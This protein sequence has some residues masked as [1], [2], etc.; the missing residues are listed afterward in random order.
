MYPI[1][2][3]DDLHDTGVVKVV[4]NLLG[5][6]LYFS[7]SLIP[8]PRQQVAHKVY[9]HVGL[10]AYRKTSL[11]RLARLP[12]TT[13]ETVES[14]EQLRWLEHG[15]R[16]RIVESVIPDRDHHGFSVDTP[17]DLARAEQMYFEKGGK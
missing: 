13:L 12:M 9:E 17:A 1:E 8:Y 5:D 2:R 16:I 15:L 7:R 6:A 4:T 10:Y 14:L 3:E 11:M